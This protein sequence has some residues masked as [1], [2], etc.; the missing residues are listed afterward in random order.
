[1]EKVKNILKFI[2]LSLAVVGFYS[3]TV[4]FTT[5]DAKNAKRS[6]NWINAREIFIPKSLSF[7]GEN[8]PL[9]RT[10]VKEQ[11]EREL[12]VNTFYHS[13]TMLL[14]KNIDRYFSIIEPI[15]KKN[16]IPDDFKYLAVAESGLSPTA[17]SPSGAI[18]LWQFLKGTATDCKLEVNKEVDERYNIEKSTQA[19]CDYL[20]YQYE[21][22][23]NWTNVAASYNTGRKNVNNQ[24]ERQKANYYYDILWNSETAR[25]VYRILAM[26][27][28]INNPTTYGFYINKKHP[29]I[30]TQK[31]EI[32]DN[33]K[34][35]ADF[36]HKHKTS[37]KTLKN[38]NPWLRENYLT[39]K[40]KKTYEITLPLKRE[41]FITKKI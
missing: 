10:D 2:L 41:N 9:K 30:Q 5:D 19:A 11:L 18:G 15:L 40:E 7:A 20:N 12:I 33:I 22:F 4:H 14:L 25:Y 16:N 34:N 24:F 26:K 38:F 28:V 1:M 35:W 8:V 13:S 39:N 32:K 17:I 36:A 3:I 23:K 6:D 27:V 29:I 37:Y 21:Y 31:I